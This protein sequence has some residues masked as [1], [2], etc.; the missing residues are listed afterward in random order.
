MV[1]SV[2]SAVTGFGLVPIGHR[3]DDFANEAD[4][5][6]CSYPLLWYSG[7]PERSAC[8]SVAVKGPASDPQVLFM[9]GIRPDV[10]LA[11]NHCTRIWV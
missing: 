10:R 11:Q 5:L 4:H 3:G 2:R 6:L 9:D 1:T 8:D 7:M